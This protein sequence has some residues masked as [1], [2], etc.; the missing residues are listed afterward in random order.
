[1][2][3]V[4]GA[5]ALVALMGAL[6]LKGVVEVQGTGQRVS[7]MQKKETGCM[8]EGATTRK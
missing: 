3:G 7:K 8:V 6:G 5:A 2:L 1:M 4:A